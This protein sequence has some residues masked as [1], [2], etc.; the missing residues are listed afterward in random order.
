MAFGYHRLRDEMMRIDA[1]QHFWR[2]SAVAYDW[3]SDEMTALRRDFLPGDLQPVLA[4]NGFNGSIVVQACQ[5]I[6][7][8]Q[9]LLELAEK[10]SFIKG[11]VGW[12]NLCSSDLPTQ[13]DSLANHS[14]LV[15]VRHVV[16]AEPDDEFMVR[17]DFR[18]GIA[19]LAGYGLTYDLLL[20]PR[21][22]PVAIKLVQQFPLQRFVLDHIAK[23]RIDEG[24]MEPWT[25]GI[26][27]LAQHE[28][29][30]CK[31]SGMVTEA[32]WKQWKPEDFRPYLDV[33]FEAFGPQRLM[34][35][36]DWPVC[37]VS[38]TYGET[39]AIVNDYI[40]PL[41]P[42]EKAQILGGNCASFYG[43]Q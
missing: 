3:I 35:G 24:L 15:G 30:C 17:N 39:I 2:Y 4:A 32:R 27:E 10:S 8:T 33:V 11:V 40:E 25:R 29:V 12:V 41:A 9:W 1:H 5:T 20:Y 28:N 14:R 43:V 34:I 38:A 23:P 37:T 18:R 6:E 42:G 36:S 22:L 21:H 19:R 16:Q 31:L 26:Q 13:L 7:E